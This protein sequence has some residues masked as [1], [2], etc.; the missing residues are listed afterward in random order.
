[1]AFL[2]D[3]FEFPDK[4]KDLLGLGESIKNDALGE[5]KR[6]ALAMEVRAMIEALAKETFKTP[7]TKVVSAL[8]SVIMEL[9]NAAIINNNYRNAVKKCATEYFALALRDFSYDQ[10][11]LAI[12]EKVDLVLLTRVSAGNIVKQ[13][14]EWVRRENEE[15]EYKL[16]YQ[17]D[18]LRQAKKEH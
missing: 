15:R 12:L 1:M 2:T 18:K 11:V 4:K 3:W 13:Q 16:R 8:K 17:A 9:G 7:D 14:M 6:P 5:I 10:D